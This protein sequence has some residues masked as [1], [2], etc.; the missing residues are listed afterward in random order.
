MNENFDETV[1]MFGL[2]LM[3]DISIFY[4]LTFAVLMSDDNY[5]DHEQNV[6]VIYIPSLRIT[7]RTA[8]KEMCKLIDLSN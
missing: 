6:I 4:H 8:L 5:I 3:N 7:Q 1:P 2:K